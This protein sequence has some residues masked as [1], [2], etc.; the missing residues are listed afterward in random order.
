MT[1]KTKKKESSASRNIAPLYDV[2]EKRRVS[3]DGGESKEP[4]TEKILKTG[5]V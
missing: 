3:P 5:D 4:A 2:R 1:K